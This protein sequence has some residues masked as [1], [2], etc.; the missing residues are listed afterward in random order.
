[1]IYASASSSRRQ[2][3]Q[4]IKSVAE[5]MA[6]QLNLDFEVVKQ[7]CGYSPIYVYYEYGGLEPIPIYCDEGKNG[8]PAEISSK[9]RGMMFVLSFH[10]RHAALREA[11]KM[12]LTLS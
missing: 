9:I 11:R 7:A 6:K 3:L 10:P 12:L 4:S 5:Q 1:M 2:R 8:D